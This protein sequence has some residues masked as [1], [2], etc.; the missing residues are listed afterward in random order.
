LSYLIDCLQYLQSA[1]GTAASSAIKVRV[2]VNG[3]AVAAVAE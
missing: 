1:D 3:V 2:R